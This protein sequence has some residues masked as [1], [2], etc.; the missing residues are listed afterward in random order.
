M[1]V[2]GYFCRGEKHAALCA[3]SIESVLKADQSA[4]VV[5]MS[6]D[7]TTLPLNYR[8]VAV[9]QFSGPKPIMLA[10]LEAQIQVLGTY[11]NSGDRVVFLDTDILMLDPL[12]FNLDQDLFVTWRDHVN[13]DKDGHPVEGLAVT[14]PYNYGVIGVLNG[15]PALRAFIWMQDRIE[16]MN[17]KLQSWYGNQ[18]ALAALCGPRPITGASTDVRTIPK[19]PTIQGATV[20]ITKLPGE[21]WN[22]TP[23]QVGERIHGMR[24]ILHFKGGSRALM[25]S[26]AKKLNLT[27]HLGAKVAA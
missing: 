4:R 5:V 8:Q 3:T 17:T 23:R 9:R 21:R 13:L 1:T 12:P 18:V 7:G 20:T 11:S 16:K 6:D 22:H 10:N 14:M 2:Y 15:L 27:W 24:S 26:Y 25:E 19:T